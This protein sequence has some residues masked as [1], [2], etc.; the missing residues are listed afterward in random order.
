[1]DN[2]TKELTDLIIAQGQVIKEQANIIL[3]LQ[4]RHMH[5]SQERDENY[6]EIVK[7]KE[8]IAELAKEGK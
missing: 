3:I 8:D 2:L 4:E 1:M 5:V 7:L 6:A